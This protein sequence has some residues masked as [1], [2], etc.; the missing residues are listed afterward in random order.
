VVTPAFPQLCELAAVAFR[1]H[2]AAQVGGTERAPETRLAMTRLIE[3]LQSALDKRE[4]LSSADVRFSASSLR[5]VTAPDRAALIDQWSLGLGR[6]DAP[7]VVVGTEHAYDLDD[8]GLSTFAVEGCSLSVLWLCGSKREV[9][10]KIAERPEWADGERGPFHFYPNDYHRVQDWRSGNHTWKC[11]AKVMAWARDDA[12]WRTYLDWATGHP[13][14]GDVAYQVELSAHPSLRAAHGFDSTPERTSFLRHLVA[15]LRDSARVLL[16]HG[17]DHSAA[18]KVRMELAVA[19]LGLPPEVQP[20][21]R[22]DELGIGLIEDGSHR[23][24]L[25]RALSMAVGDAYLRRV[26][27]YVR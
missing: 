6:D 16:L 8:Q 11:L 9:V 24:L 23:V 20:D 4:S 2:L 22:H 1:N 25:A 7:V 21:L 17:R 3:T 26:A 12:D 14:L 19:F 13:R 10:V 27:D 5:H 15:T 18:R